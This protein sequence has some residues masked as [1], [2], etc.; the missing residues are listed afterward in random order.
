ML[1][2]W[3]LS[4][5]PV[6]LALGRRHG[7]VV[8]LYVVTV[9]VLM[10]PMFGAGT[11]P[12]VDTPTFL[13]LAWV[14]EL[15]LTGKLGFTLSDPYWYGGWP[16][17]QAYP[18]LAY[19]AVGL[20]S[21]L[22]P[23]PIEIAF[24]IVVFLAYVG[25]GLSVYGLAVEF[26]LRR[27]TA[28]WAGFL[29]LVSYPVFVSLGIFGWFSTVVALP[30]GVAGLAVLERA[31]RTGDRR[32]AVVSGLLLAGSVLAHHMT[33]FAFA[34]GMVPWALYHVASATNPRRRTVRILGYSV[35]SV[36]AASGVWLVFFVV[37]ITSVGFE[38]EVAGNW[39]FDVGLMGRRMLDRSLIGQEDYPSYIGLVQ[40]PM[41]LAGVLY[42]LFARSRA[43]GVGLLLVALTL[44]AFGDG[45]MPIIRVYPF[46]G[47]DI[48]RFTVF[49]A[50]FLAF[51]SAVFLQA[52]IG[53][54]LTLKK[55]VTPPPWVVSAVVGSV[56][57]GLLVIP[58]QDALRARQTLAPINAVPQVDLAMDWLREQAPG[59]RVLGVG[60]RNWDA[61]WIPERSGL[62]IMDGWNDEGAPDWQ[63]IREVRHMGWFGRV[64]NL[65]LYRIMELRDTD[66]VVVYHWAAIDSPQLFEAALAQDPFLFQR[67][68]AWSGVTIFERLASGA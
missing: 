30:L 37:H 21:A 52:A 15:A 35:A 2:R 22:S 34:I 8:G 12:G 31:L 29:A 67:R 20:L 47:L 54:I 49:M 11:P 9:I 32:L 33:G 6:V 25:L 62:N 14:T 28:A 48:A 4:A 36:L 26:D 68:A 42:S 39:E 46:S 58:V 13:H 60:F 45:A 19:G 44:F 43:V 1:R 56:A 53:D 55:R 61:W 57:L 41:A 18:P 24:R 50:P 23:I 10:W 27:S 17:V 65:R 3:L 7:A 64:N 40:V 66:Y 38:R 63:T 16:Y 51:F 59:A 5:R